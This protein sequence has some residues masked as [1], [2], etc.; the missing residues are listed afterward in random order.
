LNSAGVEA[1]MWLERAFEESG[2]SEVVKALNNDDEAPS[3]YGFS[4]AFF[5]S[6]REVSKEDVMHLVHE[7][8]A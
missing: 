2:V 5:L 4:L 3:L 6:L 8:H 7:F 1:A